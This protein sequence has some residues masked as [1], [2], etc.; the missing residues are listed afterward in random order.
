MEV[1]ISFGQIAQPQGFNS[2]VRTSILHPALT[3]TFW[4]TLGGKN[5]YRHI[6]IEFPL[7]AQQALMPIKTRRWRIFK[8]KRRGFAYPP[9]WRGNPPTL[10]SC[11]L[12]SG[13]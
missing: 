5:H 11:L 4:V 1:G 10:S 12:S 9:F 7:R 3:V 13:I 2:R 8:G 6:S